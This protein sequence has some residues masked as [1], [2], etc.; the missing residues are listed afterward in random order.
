MNKQI[1]HLAVAASLLL[2]SGYVHAVPLIGTAGGSFASLSS[3]DNAGSSRSCRITNTAANGAN[4]QVQWGSQST[5]TDF[6]SPSTLTSVDLAFNT[7]TDAYG[8]NLGRLDW[9][10]SATVAVAD[11]DLFGVRWNLGVNFT[12]PVGPD[13]R[14]NEAFSFTINNPI[15]PRGDLIYG[16]GLS[17]LSNLA[18]SISLNGVTIENLRYQVVDGAGTGTSYFSNNIWYNDENNLSSLY[19]L[20]DFK[21]PV[22]SPIP[23]PET[24]GMLLAGLSLLGFVARKRKAAARAQ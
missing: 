20:A 15:N 23:E 22:V 18:R 13:P 7:E 9:F 19:I 8:V 24:Y 21:G 11:L 2:A 17:D 4:T 6:V 5:R 1:K 12:A 14:G 3:C 10:N 16:L